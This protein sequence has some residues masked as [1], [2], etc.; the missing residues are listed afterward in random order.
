MFERWQDFEEHIRDVFENHGFTTEFR[1]VFRSND[2]KYEIDLVARRFD[3]TLC[4]DC[5]LYGET[6]YRESRLREEARLH[7]E[8][9]REYTRKIGEQAVPI[10]VSWLDDDLI[11]EDACLFVPYRSL[12]DFL[13]NLDYYMDALGEVAN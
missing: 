8:R 6:W 12:N 4:V 10:I 5:K 2:R 3:R 9:C 7:V 13:A 1:K 11:I